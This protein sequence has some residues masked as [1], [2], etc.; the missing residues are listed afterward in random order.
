[1][2]GGHHGNRGMERVTRDRRRR[3]RDE[4]GSAL[5]LVFVVSVLLMGAMAA[6]ISASDVGGTVSTQYV[7]T[8]QASLAA[9]SGLASEISLIRAA[10]TYQA[11]PC[12][13][14]SGSLSAPGAASAFSGTVTYYATASTTTLPCNG[15]SSTPWNLGSGSA[16]PASAKILSTG[17]DAHGS[18][19]TMEE[20]LSISVAT[21]SALPDDA[22]FTENAM[23]LS[24]NGIN[25]DSYEG[26]TPSIYAEGTLTCNGT[27]TFQGTVTTYS[28]PV[29]S[30]DCTIG[31]LIA[32]GE[33]SSNDNNLVING[34]VISYGESMGVGISFTGN[35]DEINGSVQEVAGPIA[36]GGNSS[37]YISGTATASGSITLSHGA[38]VDGS[39]TCTTP[40]C[41]ANDSNAAFTGQTMPPLVTFPSENFTAAALQGDGWNV[42]QIPNSTYT[43]AQYFADDNSPVVD[44][45]QTAIAN[46]TEPTAV[47]APTCQLSYSHNGDVFKMSSDVLLQVAS[48][49]D[50]GTVTFESTVPSTASP[51]PAVH[52]NFE[53]LA[54]GTGSTPGNPVVC[55]TGSTWIT[56]T[57]DNTFDSSL[58]TLLYT[59]GQ[60]T[61][62]NNAALYGQTLACGGYGVTNGLQLYFDPSGGKELPGAA[63]APTE[64]VLDK[65]VS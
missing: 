57:Q 30:N 49:N 58:S 21:S 64:A 17:T 55:S 31:G 43:C 28:D 13:P 18:S 44:P 33:V 50:Q 38:K 20:D 23:D 60:M 10:S 65:F 56:M 15:T 34:N 32:S 51:G 41:T 14:F 47:F 4:S 42:V 46:I 6:A 39:T 3:R 59:P 11:M 36:L 62:S 25:V 27:Q 5:V 61:I 9:Q 63:G 29:F 8:S 1:M 52:H 16:V 24:G 22:L 12:Q 37:T 7:S 26:N 48:F 53:L 19:T 45:F 40:N 35:G 2:R 54:E